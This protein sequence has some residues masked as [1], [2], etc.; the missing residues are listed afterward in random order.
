MDNSMKTYIAEGKVSALRRME[1]SDCEK[2]IEWRNNDRVRLNYI[3]MEKLTLDQEVR[4]FHEKVE[5]GEVLHLIICD[6]TDG[7]KPVGCQ[8]FNDVSTFLEDPEN[9]PVEVGYFLGEDSA[10]GKG[11]AR[12]AMRL[13]IR[14]VFD[15]YGAKSAFSRIFT[16]NI[17]SINSCESI[18]MIK[19][20]LLRDVVRT[21]G[22][23]E[24]M[25]V[26][27]IT[28]ESLNEAL[29]ME[30]CRRQYRAGLLQIPEE[31]QGAEERKKVA[32]V[33][34][35]YRSEKTLPSVV[36]EID[37]TMAQEDRFDWRI[38]MVC[39]GSP[40]ATFETIQT[41][42]KEDPGRRTGIEFARNFGQHA[43]L[44]AGI[45]CAREKGADI[46]IC[47]DD[48]GQTP[49]DECGKL[50]KAIEDGA[51]AAY[52]SYEHK[53]HS[54]ARNLGTA[55]NESMTRVMLGKPKDL[56]VTSYFAMR[57]FVAD[58]VLRYRNSY[59]YLIGLVLR[60]TK[61]IVNVPVQHRKREIGTSGYTFTKLLTLWMNG[62][63]AF[64]IKPL[65]IATLC[66]SAFAFAG[67]LY[68][69]YT[70]IKKLVN[71]AVPAGFSAMMSAIVFFGGMI[72]LVLGFTGEYIG[73]TYIT[74]SSAPQYV[75]RQTT[76]D[77]QEGTNSL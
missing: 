32:F 49:A 26:L 76:D 22:T 3:Y 2:V 55:M 57:G 56:R 68:G 9:R 15:T 40:D 27:E 41:L 48:D 11:I 52:A 60:A 43:A 8:V 20:D 10:V 33:L 6:K 23:K 5:T 62:F 24:D 39:D 77:A 38:V 18:G 31:R 45:G 69:I 19:K 42:C 65:R 54:A 30:H 34:P 72:M 61:N 66:G 36:K 64:S 46:V 16:F 59:P 73:R 50:I 53:Q 13:G 35:C 4:Y 29:A 47:L 71:P 25:Y 17:T 74:V 1:L 51:D 7:Y 63:T 75:I 14:Y 44:M 70:V 58:E 28:P 67:F 21:D 37:A 12:E